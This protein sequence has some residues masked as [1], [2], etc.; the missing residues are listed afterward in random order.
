MKITKQLQTAYTNNNRQAQ[1]L[2]NHLSVRRLLEQHAT[3]L[4]L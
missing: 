1:A 2:G 4:L 3:N